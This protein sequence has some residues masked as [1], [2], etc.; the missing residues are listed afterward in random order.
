LMASAL[1]QQD[2]SLM[3]ARHFNMRTAE[4]RF[5]MVATRGA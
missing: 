4:P 1:Q 3:A 2:G 5:V